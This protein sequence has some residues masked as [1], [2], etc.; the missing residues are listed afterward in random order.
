MEPNSKLLKGDR[1]WVRAEKYGQPSVIRL[2]EVLLEVS[3]PRWREDTYVAVHYL[4]SLDSC[5]N[6]CIPKSWII[7]RCESESSL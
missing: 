2:G 3:D 1:I 6:E 7:E 4:D 5:M